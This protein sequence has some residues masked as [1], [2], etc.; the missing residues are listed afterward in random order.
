MKKIDGLLEE[1]EEHPREGSG[2]P[3]QLRHFLGEVWSRSSKKKRQTCLRNF[4]RRGFNNGYPVFR[5]L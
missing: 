4:R 5:S 3:E 1:L 2:S